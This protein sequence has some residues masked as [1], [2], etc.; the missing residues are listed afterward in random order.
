MSH[1]LDAPVPGAPAISVQGDL[2]RAWDALFSALDQFERHSG[3]LHE[4]FLFGALTKEEFGRLHAMHLADH[5]SALP[6]G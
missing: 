2:N 5:L 1:K 3:P 6:G 4:H